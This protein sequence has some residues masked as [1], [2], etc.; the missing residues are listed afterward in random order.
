MLLL[1]SIVR[2]VDGLLRARRFGRLISSRGKGLLCARKRPEWLWDLC[3]LLFVG[4]G[5]SFFEG[6]AVG[7]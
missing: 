6:K 7:T 1:R 4:T 5:D 3:S 2:V